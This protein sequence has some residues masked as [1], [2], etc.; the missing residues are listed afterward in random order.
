MVSYVIRR[1]FAMI[2]ALLGISLITFVLMHIPPGGPFTSE[3]SDARV[4]AA[5]NHAY[6]LDEP[7]WPAIAGPGAGTW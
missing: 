4:Q 5:L 3:H 7:L 2:P 6:H 1:L